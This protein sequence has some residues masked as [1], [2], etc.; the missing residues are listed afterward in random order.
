MFELNSDNL[1]NEQLE[2]IRNE[3]NI[4]LIAC[5]GSGKTRTLTYKIAYELSKL[6]SR[7]QNIIAITYTNRAADEIKERIET[8]GIDTQQL[9]IGTIH[10]FCL[11][12]ILRPYSL[13][14]DELKQGFRVINSYD[15]EKI[16]TDLCNDYNISNSLRRNQISYWDFNFNSNSTPTYYA[17]TST[18]SK[19]SAVNEIYALYLDRI[20][21]NK[22]VDFEL[23]LFYS[24]KLLI[25]LPQISKILA[26]IFPYILVDEY[27]DTKELQYY[28]LG[29]I[30]SASHQNSYLFMV[31][32][33]NQSI[34]SSLGGFAI[35]KN[36]LEV[37]TNLQISEMTLSC[38]YRSSSRIVSYFNH[39]KTYHN[40]IEAHGKYVNYESLITF[41]DRVHIDNL[42]NEIVRL[43][44]FNIIDKSIQPNEIAILAPWWFHLLSLTRNLSSRLPEYNFDGPGL[45]P[46]SSDHDNFWFKL[47]KIALTEASPNM[48]VKR[49]RWAR[50]VLKDLD[51]NHIDISSYSAKIFLRLCNSI[52]IVENDGLAYLK[53]FFTELFNLLGINIKNHL[54][55]SEHYQAFF[56][57]SESRMN[58]LIHEGIE[59]ATDIEL[60]K[61]VFRE[62]NGIT[63]SSIHGVKGAEFDTVIAFGLL[64]GL[65]PHFSDIN[66]RDSA[67]K[68]LYVIASRARKNLHFISERGRRYQPNTTIVLERYNFTY[69]Q[70][71]FDNNP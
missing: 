15:T 51:S 3:N 20:K 16:I 27:Q 10:S 64:E 21:N 52:H 66:G 11:E 37:L 58:R 6:K 7:K 41:N 14:L 31:G 4:L 2:A 24:Y 39:Y 67:K 44:Q 71:N 13:Y 22:Q 34:F 40:M 35:P 54:Y 1:N 28:I 46:F 5:P 36:A 25:D 61:K 68:Q 17:T 63:I 70:I 48:Y 45:V 55:L 29:K 38:N 53:I 57:S 30:L 23:I 26:N 62:K 32:D 12:W 69:N 50:E 49:L 18:P 9:W 47:S 59:N 56:D 19:E 33:P 8:L 65:L 43:V 60:F 42:V